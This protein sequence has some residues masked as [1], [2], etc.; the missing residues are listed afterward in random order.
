[1]AVHYKLA[2]PVSVGVDFGVGG[3][4]ACDRG[5]HEGGERQGWVAACEQVGG[6]GDVEFQEAVHGNGTL[7]GP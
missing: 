2:A 3:D 1:V 6:V 5:D 4:G 7:P